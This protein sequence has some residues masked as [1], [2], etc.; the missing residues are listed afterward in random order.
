MASCLAN[1]PKPPSIR[2][3]AQALR[4]GEVTSEELTSGLLARIRE[5]DGA[6]NAFITVTEERAL[7]DARRAD[8]EL[9]D[10]HDR[11]PMHGVPYGLKDLY[12]TAGIR[13]TCHSKLLLDNVPASDSFV[14][15]R[16][17][18]AGGV[19]L[20]KLATHEFA[21]GGPSFDLP[22]PPTR[23]PWN[24]AHNPGGSSSGPAAAVAAGMMRVAMASDTA[25][26]IRA[27][28]AYCGVVGLKPTYG[29][30]SRRG[31]FPLSYSLDHCGPIA[32]SVEDAAIALQVIAAHDPSDP[33]SADVPVPDYSADL[34]KGVAGLRIG[35]PRHFFM[36]QSGLTDDT[37]AAID[38]A[39]EGLRQDGALVE[40]LTL[41]EFSLFY[42]CGR[43]IIA[44]ESFAIHEHDLRTRPQD[45]GEITY[46]RIVVGA[47][48]TGPDLVQAFR[49]RRHLTDQVN[50]ALDRFDA[51]VTACALS[52]APPLQT[53]RDFTLRGSPIQTLPFNVTGHPA[54]SVP[55]GLGTAGL[56]LSL[57]I[58]G[59]HFDE[60][61]TLRIARSIEARHDLFSHAPSES[62]S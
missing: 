34:D 45:F 59:R 3:T 36:G 24:L 19:L 5:H 4:R 42:A 2:A 48:V 30:V 40:E 12:D 55:I 61:M 35:V 28:A 11:G 58:A 6:L 9:R 18:Q 47:G 14:A 54:L 10:G 62:Y 60:A 15:R 22:F 41:P 53:P 37:L 27:P 20:G 57:Q 52:A 44:A 7:A 51:I 13:T 43:A 8:A 1:D 26:S 39:I 46:Q 50:R 23:N 21:T 31:V 49:V 38:A 33:G 56:P 17:A 32:T 25:S 16:L 29:R